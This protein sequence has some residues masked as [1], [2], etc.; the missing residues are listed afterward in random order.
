MP[1]SKLN[2]SSTSG[3]AVEACTGSQ[4]WEAWAIHH[5]GPEQGHRPDPQGQAGAG[6]RGGELAG[7][8]RASLQIGAG[9]QQLVGGDVHAEFGRQLGTEGAV[10]ADHQNSTSPTSR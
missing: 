2:R 7:H 5:A 9:G 10:Q 3:A 4:R 8:G 1:V 6:K